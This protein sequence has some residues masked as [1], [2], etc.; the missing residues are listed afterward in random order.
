MKKIL[1]IILFLYVVQAVYCETETQA[2]QPQNYNE[3]NAGMEEN[4][5]IIENL[6]NLRWLSETTSV[7]GDS[8]TTYY[9]LQVA[10]IDASETA[11]W[12]DGEGFH[13]IGVTYNDNPDYTRLYANYDGQ[14]YCINDLTI[15]NPTFIS[16]SFF[17]NLKNSSI[18]NLNLA[19]I[20]YYGTTSGMVVMALDS[21]I[22]NCSVSGNINGGG[23]GHHGFIGS[24]HSSIISRCFANVNITVTE[25]QSS[26][27]LNGFAGGFYNSQVDN[28]YS[29]GNLILENANYTLVRCFVTD[30]ELSTINNCYTTTR[31]VSSNSAILSGWMSESQV[32]NFYW[33]TEIVNTTNVNNMVENSDLV[34]VTGYTTQE[35]KDSATYIQNGWDFEEVWSIDPEINDGYPFL[36]WLLSSTPNSELDN[37]LVPIRLSVTNYPNPFNP[38]TTIEFNNPVQGQ[39]N[40]NIYNLKG[41]LVKNLLKDN[42]SK[43]I[44]KVLWQGRDNNAQQVVSG[45]YFFKISSGNNQSVT[46]KIILMK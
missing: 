8:L 34:N 33:D 1:L 12:N 30:V 4:P 18:R 45:V 5:L 9:F 44:H 42:L 43:G 32:N 37:S 36:Q 41:Q 29:R 38:E 19:N 22:V 26:V 6:A 40:I 7:W 11:I 20:S 14:G 27:T 16:R 15:N 13:P 24:S 3:P 10:D 23:W 35:M 21:E 31:V 25:P 28:C 39:V 2:L 17:G 46:K